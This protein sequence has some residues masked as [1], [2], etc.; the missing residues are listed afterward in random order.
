MSALLDF[1]FLRPLWLLA[2]VPLAITAVLLLRRRMETGRWREVIDPAL[3]PWLIESGWRGMA[4]PA[5]AALLAAWALASVALAGPTWEQRPQPVGRGDDALVIVLDMSLSMYA[6]DIAPSRLIRARLK[7]ADVLG[8]RADGRT[9][10]IVYAGST[11]VV[12]PLTD[13]VRTINNLLTALEPAIMPVLGSRVDEAL[14]R[15]ATLLDDAAAPDGRI[16][17]VTDGLDDPDRV[18]ASLDGRYRVSVLAVGTEDGG[19]IPMNAVGRSGYLDAGGRTV[20][21]RLDPTPLQRLASETGGRF[22]L[23]TTN[24]SDLDRVLGRSGTGEDPGEREREFELWIDAGPWLV[25]LL[26]PVAVAAFR[27]GLVAVVALGILVAA[28]TA[29]APG[30]EAAAAPQPGPDAVPTG[31]D[32]REAE[33]PTLLERLF[34][35]P[36]QRAYAA[37]RRGRP[38]TAVASFDDPAW[39]A[40][41]LYRNGEYDAA[42]RAWALA[43]PSL[44]SAETA[45]NQGNALAFA[46]RFEEAIAAYDAALELDPDHVDA[47]HNRDIVEKLLEG[48]RQ[49][50]QNQQGDQQQDPNAEEDSE[51]SASQPSQEQGDA[52]GDGDQEPGEAGEGQDPGD[53]EQEASGEAPGEE[54]EQPSEAEQDARLAQR[55][56]ERE[57]AL[58]QWL[59]RVPDEPGALLQRK[60]RYE[61]ERRYRQGLKR[62]PEDTQPW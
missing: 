36:D 6:E 37:L 30:A 34:S 11:H 18:F 15:A 42:A 27:R 48:E 8:T 32:T 7:V 9:A 25:L 26:L 57:Q 45:Y 60:F 12:V 56:R 33:R 46:Q 55:S 21:V 31:P 39:R 29:R 14:T 35:T 40:T 49:D 3:A 16:L 41:A 23:F 62:T 24:D 4:R 10:L 54:G 50:A 44:D 59:R 17:L 2:L 53:R 22:A 58:E 51:S 47:R 5:V 19:P 43:D 52:Q 1:H 28:E 38:D 20:V 13:D 61:T